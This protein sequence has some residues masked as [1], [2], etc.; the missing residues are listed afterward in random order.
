MR[1]I[2]S[3]SS[4]AVLAPVLVLVVLFSCVGM[5]IAAAAVQDVLKLNEGQ[6][7][8]R[9][10][11]P[12]RVARISYDA[13]LNSNQFEGDT[14][15]FHIFVDKVEKAPILDDYVL[16]L[17]TNLENPEWKFGDDLYHSA[18]VIVWE[19]EEAHTRMVPEI[20]L[21]GEVPAPIITIKEPG[22]NYDIDGIGQDKVYVKLT[23]G[24]VKE[25]EGATLKTIIQKLEPTMTFF[26][27]NEGIQSA[28]S[29]MDENLEVAKGKIGETELGKDIE[30]LYKN[31]HPGWASKLSTDY[32]ALSVVAEP[33]P[34]MLYALAAM[35][36]GLILGAGF[37][38]VY[39]SRGGGKGVDVS[40]ISSEL[41]DTSGRI[42]EKS[43]AINAI[44]TRFARSADEEQ[45]G[46]ARELLK[47][48]ASLNE[49]ANELRAIAD[50]IRGSR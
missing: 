48:R 17:E 5:S 6:S 3:Y 50:R 29:E 35:I 49:L 25:K 44:S 14:L 39:V 43:G 47:I 30:E 46:A 15:E 20:I 2:L 8:V 32:K 33:P 22:F 1:R 19:G 9:N 45:R 12:S 34:I 21:S 16:K 23:V 31:G 7:Y 42:A 27:T 37:V 40:E 24:T 4:L 38:Y 36:L 10:L 13:F 18:E 26:S 28:K 41:D 11:E